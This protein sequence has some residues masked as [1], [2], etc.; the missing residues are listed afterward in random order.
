MSSSVLGYMIFPTNFFVGKASSLI[1][2]IIAVL[3]HWDGFGLSRYHINHH[4][5][6]TRNYGSHI[7]I[8]DIYFK[9]YQWEEYEH[10]DSLRFPRSSES[11]SVHKRQNA[12]AVD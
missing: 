2:M 6:V 10:P 8:F 3:S 7:P 9:T 1:Y 4:Y 12:N 11:E 5:L